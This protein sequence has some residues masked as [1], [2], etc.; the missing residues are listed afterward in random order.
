MPITKIKTG[1]EKLDLELSKIITD[2]NLIQSFFSDLEEFE[3]KEDGYITI[4]LDKEVPAEKDNNF[5]ISLDWY[6]AM[7]EEGLAVLNKIIFLLDDNYQQFMINLNNAPLN[8]RHKSFGIPLVVLLA[9]NPKGFE[10]LKN[11]TICLNNINLD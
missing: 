2:E 8:E 7:T 4:D 11:E 5:G 9:E 10:V 6:L 1:N 3:A